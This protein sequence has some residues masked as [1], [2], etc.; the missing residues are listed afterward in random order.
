M[1][2]QFPE[3]LAKMVEQ[4]L[5]RL[6][7]PLDLFLILALG[8]P[9]AVLNAWSSHSTSKSEKSF[10]VARGPASRDVV[11]HFPKTLS[12]PLACLILEFLLRAEKIEKFDVGLP[13]PQICCCENTFYG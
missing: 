9:E 10:I 3:W 12:K 7:C 5:L 13:S 6:V 4:E 1:T 11:V 8:E 2:D